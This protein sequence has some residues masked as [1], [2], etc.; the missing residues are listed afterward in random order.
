MQTAVQWL[1]EQITICFENYSETTLFHRVQEKIE[2][3]KQ[4]EKSNRF[5]EED[6][7]RAFEYGK[8]VIL[9]NSRGNYTS[10]KEREQAF[11]QLLTQP[12]DTWDVYFDSDN[13]L[14]LK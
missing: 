13:N 9:F 4:M 3:A 6:M 2:Q 12:K 10:Q 11:E 1:D 5:S 7:R 14:K 8:E